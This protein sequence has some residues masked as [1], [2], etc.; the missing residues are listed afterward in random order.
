[1][2][3]P[4]RALGGALTRVVVGQ[5]DVLQAIAVA[6]VAGGHVLIEGAPGLAKTLACKALAGALDATFSRIQFTCDLMPS[7]I[8]GC[9][10]FDPRSAT[11]A[12]RRGPIFATVV[13]ADELNRA[14][15]RVQSALLEAMQERHVTIGFE[16]LALPD[17]FFV[18]A[19]VNPEDDGA[20][21]LPQA[22]L[23]R[24]MMSVRARYPEP[25]EEAAILERSGSAVPDFGPVATVEDAIP[26]R[27]AAAG[28]HIAPQIKE[29]ILRIVFA[30][31]RHVTD[32]RRA[33]GPRAT[34]AIAACARAIASCDERDFVIPDD[35]RIVAPLVL[36]H[37][38]GRTGLPGDDAGAAEIVASV[39][40]P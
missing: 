17:P 24:F 10:V 34:L 29:Y 3:A 13:L 28:V 21:A 25:N 37:R 26:W 2:P 40:T 36:R 12:T 23:D 18:L 8:I 22:Q 11:F 7:D 15:A 35:V 33:A 9:R 4:A 27:A 5:Q 31:R 30:T 39:P 6:F 1:M 38:I 32:E 20:Y 16:T 14:P 19:T